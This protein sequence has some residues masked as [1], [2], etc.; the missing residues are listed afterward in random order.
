[1]AKTAL[2]VG[3]ERHGWQLH[4]Q[5]LFLDQLERLLHAVNRARHAD[6]QG[7]QATADAKLLGALRGLVQDGI[8][9]DPFAPEFRQGNTLGSAYRH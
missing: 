8:P 9:R 1:M 5:P 7:W 3:V 4:A 6:P 2:A